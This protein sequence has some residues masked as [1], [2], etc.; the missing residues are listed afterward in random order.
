MSVEMLVS[1]AN[2][3]D[4]QLPRRPRC[5]DSNDKWRQ[6]LLTT[7]ES[8]E[9]ITRRQDVGKH[10]GNRKVIT[11]L[12]IRPFMWCDECASGCEFRRRMESEGK[13][14]RVSPGRAAK[15][16]LRALL[17]DGPMM[18]ADVQARAVAA[19]FTWRTGQ[20]ASV[21]AGVASRR[22]YFSGGAE[23]SLPESIRAR[24]LASRAK[25]ATAI[26]DATTHAHKKTGAPTL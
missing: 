12:A 11:I 17:V 2:L 21:A 24:F 4:K 8:G 10:A 16:W 14:E 5:F 22:A 25:F 13:C 7:H 26:C 19:G 9:S 3:L 18:S 20:R 15:Q 6:Y 23:W 1:A